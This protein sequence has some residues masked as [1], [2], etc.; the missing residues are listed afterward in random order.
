MQIVFSR[1]IKSNTGEKGGS[2]EAELFIACFV[3]V[4]RGIGV[5]ETAKK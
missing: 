1:K 4:S 5:R 3:V 2:G